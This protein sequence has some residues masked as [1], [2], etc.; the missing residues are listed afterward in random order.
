MRIRILFLLT[1]SP[2]WKVPSTLTTLSSEN[3]RQIFDLIPWSNPCLGLADRLTDIFPGPL[4][5]AAL[6]LLPL[7]PVNLERIGTINF[8]NIDATYFRKLGWSWLFFTLP[9]SPY[10][11]LWIAVDYLVDGIAT[12]GGRFTNTSSAL[13]PQVHADLTWFVH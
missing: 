11:P 1:S 13:A 7:D 5:A 10:G 8:K 3:L 9:V 2:S 6:L 12:E 4:K